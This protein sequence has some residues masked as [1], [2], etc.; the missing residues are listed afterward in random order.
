MYHNKM[1]TDHKVPC[2]GAGGVPLKIYEKGLAIMFQVK[3]GIKGDR[4]GLAGKVNLMQQHLQQH[5]EYVQ[6]LK[7]VRTN[8]IAGDCMLGGTDGTVEIH[9]TDDDVRAA[10]RAAAK[11]LEGLDEND[12]GYSNSKSLL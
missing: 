8:I 5:A 11:A 1:S 2:L 4:G 9:A 12:K 7:F 3:R 10:N 6:M